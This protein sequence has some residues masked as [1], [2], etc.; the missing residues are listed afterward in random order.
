MDI[1]SISK[2]P[3]PPHP[4]PLSIEYI[5]LYRQEY[6]LSDLCMLMLIFV[7]SFFDVPDRLS[8]VF[9]QIEQCKSQTSSDF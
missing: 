6:M 4:P 3:T 2:A 1:G 7:D 5:Y 9:V 8:C